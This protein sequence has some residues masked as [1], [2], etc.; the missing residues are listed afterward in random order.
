ISLVQFTR[1]PVL[2]FSFRK[3]NCKPCLLADIGD[4]EYISDLNSVDNIIHKVVK[5]GFSKRRGDRDEVPNV[6][7]MIT[8][9]MSSGQFHE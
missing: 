1:E 5:Y 6:L 2:E 8:N 4:T 7:V 3:H 9:G